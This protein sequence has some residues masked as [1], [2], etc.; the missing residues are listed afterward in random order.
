ME[1]IRINQEYVKDFMK[2]QELESLMDKANEMN[3]IL[4]QRKGKGSEFLGWVS[5]PAMITQDHIKQIQDIAS[6]LRSMS[7]VLVVVGIGGSYLGSKATIEALSPF[8]TQKNVIYAGIHLNELYL[9]QLLEYIEDKEFALCVISKS[10]TTLEPAVAFRELRELA[11]KKYGSQAKERIVAITNPKKGNLL[12]LAKKEGYTTLAIPDDIGGRYSIFTP[13]GL[14]PIAYAGI[15]IEKLIDGA[16]VMQIHTVAENKGNLAEQYAA[17]RN[18]LYMNGFNVEILTTYSAQLEYVQR[19]WQQLYGESE[20]KEGKGIFPAVA[21][22]TTD[23]HSLGQY[24]QQGPRNLFETVL[25]DQHKPQLISVQ[26][27]PEDF[28]GLNY[29]SG[30][31]ISEINQKAFEGTVKAH[32]QGGVPNIVVELPVINEFILGQVFYFFMRACG[33]SG[34]MLG[35]NP[36]DQPG[37]EFYKQNMFKLLG[38]PGF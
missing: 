33:I 34:Y 30:K 26:S 4:E 31:S 18:S 11:Y 1:M 12:T 20:G 17:L 5:Q 38:R 36:F 24:I 29:L 13:A 7:D 10:G 23:L 9:Y 25:F 32:V 15:D 8:F 3:H 28:D 6:R 21:Q 14:L 2:A 35:I 19:W 27:E 37:V 16:R 22:F